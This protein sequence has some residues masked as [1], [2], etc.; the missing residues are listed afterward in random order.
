MSSIF[1]EEKLNNKKTISVLILITV[2]GAFIGFI[3]ET[4]LYR[5]DLGYFVKR[6]S[7]F[8]PWVPIYGYG[9]F[10]LTIFLYKYKNKPL[11]VFIFSTI[12]TGT[13]E[14]LT[15]Y[16]LD[17]FLG[18]R[19]WD[20]NTEILNFGNINGYICFRSVFLFG[21][22]GLFLI[23]VLIPKIITFIKK[24]NEDKLLIF[25]SIIGIIYFVDLLLYMI[26]K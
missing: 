9:A 3:Y 12:I 16:V 25:S 18:K 6:G 17:N 13:L 7:S 15:G 14:Y 1:K 26:I 2:L 19:L 8:G 23:E 22:G 24:I 5:I 4:I 21:I 10:F 11:L 20:Y